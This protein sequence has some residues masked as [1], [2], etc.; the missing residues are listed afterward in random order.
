MM[1]KTCFIFLICILIIGGCTKEKDKSAVQKPKEA[2]NVLPPPPMP[3]R[4]QASVK[5]WDGIVLK[6]ICLVVKENFPQIKGELPMSIGKPVKTILTR[7]GIDIVPKGSPCDATLTI[8]LKGQTFKAKYHFGPIGVGECYSGGKVNGQILLTAKGYQTLAIP[9]N[10]DDPVPEK[11][12][13]NWFYKHQKPEDYNF[14]ELWFEPLIDGLVALWGPQVLVCA[15]DV[16][17]S[18]ATYWRNA[19]IYSRLMKIGPVDEVVNALIYA[20]QDSNHTLKKY[21]A[22]MFGEFAPNAKEGIPFLSQVLIEEVKGRL[23]KELKYWVNWDVAIA[24]GKYGPAA[25]YAV[26]NLIK[27][28]YIAK[29]EQNYLKGVDTHCADAL[30]KIT[31]KSSGWEDWWK[32]HK[33]RNKTE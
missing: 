24:L 16:T 8:K 7:M 32:R 17:K 14:R 6:K 1:K 5:R 25:K 31:G 13:E 10:G 18:G 30:E 12:S 29:K 22:N 26:P 2:L 20:L 4:I 33:T 27:A 15:L 28:Y 21:A 19:P 11:V 23:K 9:I 3:E